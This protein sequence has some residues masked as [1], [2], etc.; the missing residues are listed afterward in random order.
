MRSYVSYLKNFIFRFEYA[1]DM[2][3]HSSDMYWIWFKCASDIIGHD[4]YTT[5]T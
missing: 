4:S 1:L 5:R 3:G 2:V